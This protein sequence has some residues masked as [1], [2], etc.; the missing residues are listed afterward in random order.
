MTPE[1]HGSESCPSI[2]LILAQHDTPLLQPD[3]KFS[4]VGILDMDTLK[5]HVRNESCQ[6]TCCQQEFRAIFSVRST[7]K[8]LSATDT[9]PKRTTIKMDL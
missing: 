4:A 9:G 5:M 6:Q 2:D 7:V 1:Q 3:G 8:V